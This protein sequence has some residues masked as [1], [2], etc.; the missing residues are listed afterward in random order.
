VT[1]QK[2]EITFSMW[3]SIF[4]LEKVKKFLEKVGDIETKDNNGNTLLNLAVKL[5]TDDF[6]E[7]PTEEINQDY[8]AGGITEYLIEMGANLETK[9][10]NGNTPLI[11]DS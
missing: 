3:S 4:S 10:L 6:P 7:N 9:D 5:R 8:F 11:N 2:M 1:N